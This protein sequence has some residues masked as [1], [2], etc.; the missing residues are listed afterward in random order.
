MSDLLKH[1][2]LAWAAIDLVS[3]I[4][5][6]AVKSFTPRLAHDGIAI[7]GGIGAALAFA[8]LHRILFGVRVV[9]FGL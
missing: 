9:P 1:L 2:L 8:Y 5:R 6:N 3:A 7:V 4:A